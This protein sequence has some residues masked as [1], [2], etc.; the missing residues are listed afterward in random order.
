MAEIF[1]PTYTV[2]DPKTGKRTKR[3]SRTW[4]IRYYTPD[5][6]R[7]RVKGYRDKKATE[8][9]AAELERRGIR[10]DAGL[11]DP[12]AIHAKT[13]LA[14]H[15]ADYLRDLQSKGRCRG[16]V[17]KTEARIKTVLAGCGFV[18]IRD[19]NAEKVAALL[20]ALRQQRPRPE[21]PIGKSWF[22]P[23]EMIAAL[24]GARPAQL[25]RFLRRE[26]LQVEGKGNARRYPRPTVEALQDRFCRGIG[27]STSNGYLA[28]IKGLS[29]WLADKERT[30]RDR[31]TSLKALNAD[32]D[33]RHERRALELAE[34]QSLLAAAERS[35]VVVHGMGG[36]DRAMLYAVAMVTGF[37]ASELASLFPYSF[38]LAGQPAVVTVKAAYAKNKKAADQPLP[39]DVTEALREYLNGKLRDQVVWPGKWFRDAAEMLRVD[40]EAAGIPY[41]DEAGRVAD[42]HALRHSYITLLERS[43]VSPKLA[44]ELARHSDI[45]LT[46]NVY[47]HAGLYD[48]AAAVAGLP[49]ILQPHN[50]ANAAVGV[51][52]ATGTEELAPRTATPNRAETLSISLGPNLVP[53]RASEGDFQRR[54]ETIGSGLSPKEN[55]GKTAV[56]CV[57]PGD[58]FKLPGQD[59]NLDKENQKS[60]EQEGNHL[61]DKSYGNGADRVAPGVAQN[62]ADPDLALIVQ[63]WRDL[64]ETIRR[65]MLALIGSVTG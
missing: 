47:T 18:F 1:R 60:I 9:L 28:A 45:R 61:Q 41:R 23:R 15:L 33:P 30:D 39:A 25:A 35:S 34:L 38:D 13:P 8:N 27:I 40:L 48:L 42:F 44:Q 4:H 58:L 20:H 52:R 19:L 63:A 11:V 2:A 64:P 59:S 49:A 17:Q 32:T 57:F 31:L 29:R 62:L 7:H 22:T 43:G 3:K 53:D 36:P 54:S 51:L 37:R 5:G 24:N 46:M 14:E 10:V 6:E 56:S 16:H 21:L 12:N 50:A 65:A 26:G 55:P